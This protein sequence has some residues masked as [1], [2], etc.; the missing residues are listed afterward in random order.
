[1]GT[2]TFT[3]QTATPPQTLTKTFTDTD[4]NI[5]LALTAMQNIYGGVTPA[6]AALAW[7]TQMVANLVATTTNYQHAAAPA[8]IINPQ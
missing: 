4:A 8:T 3:V 7:A 6:Q 5:V 2:L 1:M